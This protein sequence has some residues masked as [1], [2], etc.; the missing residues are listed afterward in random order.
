M[1]KILR[2]KELAPSIKL[3]E[4]LAPHIA[5]KAQ[6][7]QFVILRVDEQ[8]ERF[9]L[10][11]VDWDREKG[12]I[13]LIF[14]EV[15]VSTKKLG[16]LDEGE[17]LLDVAGPLGNPSE[18]K[19]YGALGVVGGGVGTASAYPIARALKEAGNKVISIVGAKTVGLLIL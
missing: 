4:V 11:L 15:G 1:Y 8:G 16:A 19:N 10:T 13:T 7:G 12:T 9:P 14:L 18:I 6:P 2:K 17:V 5:E 3:V